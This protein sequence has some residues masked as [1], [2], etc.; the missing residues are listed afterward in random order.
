MSFEDYFELVDLPA[1][2]ITG[3]FDNCQWGALYMYSG[4]A[5]RS[6]GGGSQWL[7]MGPWDHAGSANPQP[8]LGD[9][10]FTQEAVL[11][12]RAIHLRWFDY[13]LKGEENGQGDDAKVRIFTMGRNRW[14]DERAWP[15]RG[16]EQVAFY[17]HSGGAADV[18]P[19]GGRATGSGGRLT[20]RWMG[21]RPQR[22]SATSKYTTPMIP[23]PRWKT[24]SRPIP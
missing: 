20:G 17:L 9:L 12:I 6:P 13:W 15:V 1:L 21:R 19:E 3:W 4:M 22:R 24:R 5:A 10:E 7:L 18:L 2:H 16:M 8:R 23:C 14:R 11:D